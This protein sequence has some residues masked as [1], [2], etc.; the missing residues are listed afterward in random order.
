GQ[1]A[2]SEGLLPGGVYVGQ[3]PGYSLYD[4]LAVQAN[5]DVCVATLLNSGISTISPKGKVKFTSLAQYADPLVTN[6]AFGGKDMKTAW[7]TLS[8]PGLLVSLPRPQPRPP[9]P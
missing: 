8:G 3:T 4:S 7:I 1:L 6:I 5:G 2:K 9:L